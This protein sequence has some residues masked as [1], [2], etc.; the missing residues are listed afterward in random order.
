[1]V[2]LALTLGAV[3][4]IGIN[5]AHEL[6]HEKESSERWLARV[7]LAQCFYGH[8]HIEHNRGHHVR[9]ATP[10]DPASSRMEAERDDWI[11]QRNAA[12]LATVTS[13]LSS[14][15]SDGGD[16]LGYDLD[17]PH[18]GA[19]LWCGTDVD[20]ADRLRRLERTVPQVAATLGCALRPLVVAPDAST[21]WGWFPSTTG[22]GRPIR[23][24]R[25]V[26]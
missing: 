23:W 7:A 2:G 16:A 1:M 21:L 26:P 4:G 12:R 10:D 22:P 17:G 3:A 9:V 13:L 20:E 14:R 18:V 5:T 15:T 19:V 25:M 6:G 8:F 11:R 24:Q